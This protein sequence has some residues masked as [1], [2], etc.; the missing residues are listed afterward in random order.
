MPAAFGDDHPDTVSLHNTVTAIRDARADDAEPAPS[1]RTPTPQQR[2]TH[3][4]VRSSVLNGPAVGPTPTVSSDALSCR[5]RVRWT[6]HSTR[7]LL[8]KCNP[9]QSIEDGWEHVEFDYVRFGP[10]SVLR[11]VLREDRRD[12][13][14]PTA[15]V[16][17]Y[18]GLVN[19]YG[20]RT[21]DQTASRLLQA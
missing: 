2:R 21:V 13:W 6:A 10:T 11:Y 16:L 1:A 8:S 19:A 4:P 9:G 14:A 20:R 18:L 12:A 17:F 7:G 15:P 3:H 5:M